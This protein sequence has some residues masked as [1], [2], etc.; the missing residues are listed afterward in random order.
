MARIN[1]AWYILSDPARR[2]KWDEWRARATTAP[3][4]WAAS[5][6]PARAPTRPRAT[7]PATSRR[8]SGWMAAGIV[9][10]VA[11]L[12]GITMVAV[13]A[14]ST[15]ADPRLAFEGDG[16]EFLYDP[17]WTVVEGDTQGAPAHRLLAHL[18]TWDAD[19]ESLC[20]TYGEACGIP[21]VE[22]PAGGASVLITA[23]EGGVPPVPEPVVTRPFGLDADAIIGGQPAAFDL[24]EVDDDLSIAWWQLS[25]PRFPDRWIE[26]HALIRS[27]EVLES[28]VMGDL[29]R[30]LDSIDFREETWGGA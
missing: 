14:A 3:P 21:P 20:T 1:E 10:A 11:A 22:I 6:M 25:P 7:E 4:H 24:E 29:Q 16:L 12:V 8:D 15:P 9:V 17:T 18:V 13:S 26:V 19:P 5:P 30:L 2:A 28:E 23:F 27:P